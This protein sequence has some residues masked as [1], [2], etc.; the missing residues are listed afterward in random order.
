MKELFLETDDF[1]GELEIFRGSGRV[2]QFTSDLHNVYIEHE[3]LR[4]SGRVFYQFTSDLHNVYIEHEILRGSGRVFQFTSDIY[5]NMNMGSY[6]TPVV[7]YVYYGPVIS[8]FCQFGILP[9]FCLVFN[10][11]Y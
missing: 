7:Y 2:F 8:K 10:V 6:G 4:G 11:C 9:C 3:I 5:N 1:A